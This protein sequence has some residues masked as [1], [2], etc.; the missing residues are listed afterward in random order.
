[1]GHRIET[2]EG[3]TATAAIPI[4]IEV[5]PVTVVG[6]VIEE[7]VETLAAEGRARPCR[8]LRSH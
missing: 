3:I 6:A 7:A 2:L 5:T 4:G 8:L 1:M